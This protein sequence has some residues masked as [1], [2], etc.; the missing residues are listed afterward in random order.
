M[1]EDGGQLGRFKV[2]NLMRELDLVSKQPGSHAYKR[3]TV[4]R[5]D[6]P[7]TLNRE[8]DVPAPN[9]VRCGDKDQML[10]QYC[11]LANKVLTKPKPIGK[12]T[13]LT[14]YPDTRNLPQPQS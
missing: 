5:L 3:A 2:R 4:D 9:Q 6:I 7:N 13:V 12:E 1:R 14:F 8:F 10:S 11:D